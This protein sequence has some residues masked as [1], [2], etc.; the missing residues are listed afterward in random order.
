LKTGPTVNTKPLDNG[1]ELAKQVGILAAAW[2]AASLAWKGIKSMLPGG[3]TTTT[4]TTTTTTESA[5]TSASP[6]AMTGAE[7]RQAEKGM[8]ASERQRFRAEQT[9]L[10]RASEAQAAQV[11]AKT[12]A[13]V[14]K[15]A[16]QSAKYA[17]YLKFLG[18]GNVALQGLFFGKD[19]LDIKDRKDKNE[20]DE[21]QANAEYTGKTAETA[22]A[23]ASSL[24][25]GKLGALIG[26]GIGVWFGVAGAGP[27]ALIGGLIGS[28][29][30]ALTYYL[31]DVGKYINGLGQTASKW[32][33][34]S[35]FIEKIKGMWDTLGTSMTS[36]ADWIGEKFS[37]DSI[38]NMIT[39]G[40][41][42]SSAAK[43]SASSS[44]SVATQVTASLP[45]GLKVLSNG[46][47]GI[48]FVTGGNAVDFTI[49]AK[50]ILV[51]AFTTA[52]KN[53]QG[54]AGALNTTNYST[55]FYKPKL[56]PQ[57]KEVTEADFAEIGKG[58]PVVY[59]LGKLTKIAAESATDMRS[60]ATKMGASLDT[61]GDSKRYLRSMAGAFNR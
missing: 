46:G 32:W 33:Q 58:D 26:A 35:K 28:I 42:S 40:A 1:V 2:A 50:T 14:A 48:S 30:G 56:N 38:K 11:A 5:R 15:A 39:F 27:G 16:A 13:E 60:L 49:G 12:E 10:L 31:T 51:E 52:L 55:G 41:S 4:P 9:A 19:L 8:R 37:F 3:T 54:G 24:A 23:I 43:P 17:K 57:G 47:L 45:A 29:G 20:I 61:A 44:T 22:G 34:D 6:K 25:G 18:R 59:A 53:A 21:R 36:I 7:M